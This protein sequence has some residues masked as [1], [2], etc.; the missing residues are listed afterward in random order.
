MLEGKEARQH[1]VEALRQALPD[2]LAVYGFG[3]RVHGTATPDSDWDLAILV[4]GKVDPARLW[5]LAGDLADVLGSTVDLVD[6]RAA[7]TVLQYQV[8]TTGERWWRRD[9]RAD[10]Y[11]TAILSE[12][13]ALDEARAGLIGD[14]L[15]EGRVYGR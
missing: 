12:K 4:P 5:D 10:L 7:S 1:V 15:R 2:L 8:I 13:T 9:S 11:E 14:I 6:L 3:S